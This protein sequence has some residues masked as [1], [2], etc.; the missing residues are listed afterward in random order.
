M[1]DYTPPQQLPGKQRSPRRRLLWII[2][3]AVMA[4]V[5]A[6]AGLVVAVVAV[7]RNSPATAL[8]R[9]YYDAVKSQNY[10][11]AFQYLDPSGLS[12]DNQPATEPLYIQAARAFD[13]QKGK[14]TD[15]SIPNISI[16]STNGVNTAAMTV[17]LTRS[18]QAYDVHLL[19]RQ[20]GNDWKIV[21]LDS[22]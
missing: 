4:F 12:I 9:Q 1:L 22:F 21:S 15:Y 7:T 5:V 18:G 11:T 14:V 6:I 8:T 10:A 2:L 13:A 3:I 17:R 19:L 16:N 20:E